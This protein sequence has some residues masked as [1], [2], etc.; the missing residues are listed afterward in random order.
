MT[1]VTCGLPNSS[2]LQD[3]QVE[4]QLLGA[5]LVNN[6]V[7]D[8]VAC[9]LRSEYFTDPLHRLMYDVMVVK[10]TG[11]KFVSPVTL[12]S[13]LQHSD[14]LKARGGTSFFERLAGVAI[15]PDVAID[16]AEIIRDLA[17][18]RSLVQIGKELIDSPMTWWRAAS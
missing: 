11:N 12:N 14:E 1:D 18:R 16:Y 3:V 9:L 15:S 13:Y 2:A 5:I 7:F 6:D 8:R 10:I 4:Q 17:V